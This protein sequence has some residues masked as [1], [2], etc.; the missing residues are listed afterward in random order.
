MNSA[1]LMLLGMHALGD[2]YLQSDKLAQTKQY[3]YA[4]LAKH[5]LLY[6]LAFVP[7]LCIAPWI[8]F[9]IL[10]VSASSSPFPMPR[11]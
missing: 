9:A 7:L 11:I 4:P 10:V 6:A 2:F 1:V 8:V 5:S 3:A